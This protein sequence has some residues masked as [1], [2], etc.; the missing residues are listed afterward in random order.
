MPVPKT[1][2]ET[3]V[4][5]NVPMNGQQT[6]GNSS[7]PPKKSAGV[8]LGT[9]GGIG[10]AVS[11]VIMQKETNRQ[12]E[13]LQDKANAHNIKLWNMQNEYNK[14]I[15][16]MARLREAGLNPN[17]MYGLPS[18]QA[19]MAHQADTTGKAV[20][21]QIDPLTLAN[22][23]LMKAQSDKTQTEA[24]LLKQ[25][26]PYKEDTVKQ[27]LENLQTLGRTM[28]EEE[29][30]AKLE[31]FIKD[32]TVFEEI[33][34]KYS[35]REL[36]EAQTREATNRANVLM[37]QWMMS[38]HDAEAKKYFVE[39]SKQM[40]ELEYETAVRANAQ[41]KIDKDNYTKLFGTMEGESNT[42]KLIM[43]LLKEFMSMR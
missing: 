7:G 12:N 43:Y 15:N 31:T 14:P 42:F 38:K 20:A 33:Y 11:N 10:G 41:D 40:T 25:E 29:A 22:V 39:K 26:L 28:K 8:I 21:P 1:N 18:S 32:E 27:T 35:I 30:Q 37:Y 36:T 23:Q 2:N 5:D 13:R 6:G 19:E 3:T 17:L 34:Q 24:N 9:I 16:Q 4:L